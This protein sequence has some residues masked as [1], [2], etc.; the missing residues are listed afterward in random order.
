M[1][2]RTWPRLGLHNDSHWDAQ[3]GGGC[4][5][6][7]GARSLELEGR[8]MGSVGTWRHAHECRDGNMRSLVDGWVVVCISDSMHRIVGIDTQ[9][10]AVGSL[11]RQSTTSE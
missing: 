4:R 6:E 1:R 5:E 2:M 9:K 8:D 10:L 7:L 3:R 11:S